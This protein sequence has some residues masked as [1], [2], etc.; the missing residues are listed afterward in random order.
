MAL[1]F[2]EA[3]S[4]LEAD[5]FLVGHDGWRAKQNRDDRYPIHFLERRVRIDHAM[6]RGLRFRISVFPTFPDTA[7]FQCEEPGR[8]SCLTLYR[9]EW[10]P[11]SGHA[12]GMGPPTPPDLRGLSFLPGETHEH[13]CVDNVTHVE[14]RIIK[15]G[16][17][18]ARRVEPDF[19]SYD[20]ALAY[21]CGKL[22]IANPGVIPPSNAQ[23]AL[24]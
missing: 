1:G 10:R 17:H 8:R 12:N 15:P 6:P 2:E 23:W 7:T 9:L 14:K 13:V 20:D 18:A 4:Y 22:R 16:V 19:A 3:R 5:K 24:V 21:V 11:I